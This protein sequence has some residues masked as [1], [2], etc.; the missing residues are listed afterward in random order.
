MNALLY[1][2][3][4]IVVITMAAGLERAIVAIF[5]IIEVQVNYL[6]EAL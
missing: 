1:L 2:P 4:V 6:I 3:G 5:F